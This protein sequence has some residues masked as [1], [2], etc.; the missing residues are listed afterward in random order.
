MTQV[1]Q[2]VITHGRSDLI[3]VGKVANKGKSDKDGNEDIDD[4]DAGEEEE[5]DVDEEEE[6]VEDDGGDGKEKSDDS[7]KRKKKDKYG[8]KRGWSPKTSIAVDED[9]VRFH[10]WLTQT[11]P[12]V[13]RR[14]LLRFPKR[15]SKYSFATQTKAIKIFS[16][17][18]LS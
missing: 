9:K 6:V 8:K 11:L 13:L 4:E 12:N 2:S 3:K 14:P 10:L 15:N 5:K 17:I 18:L 1:H 7:E 16:W